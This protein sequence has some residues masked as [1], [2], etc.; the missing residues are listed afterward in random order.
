MPIASKINSGIMITV[1]NCG[2]TN[3]SAID[4]IS[5]DQVIKVR[6]AVIRLMLF[7]RPN[8]IKRVAPKSIIGVICP[9]ITSGSGR[10]YRR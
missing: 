8:M 5:Q 3:S 2:C 4:K 6:A 10:K 9:S 7:N 1:V